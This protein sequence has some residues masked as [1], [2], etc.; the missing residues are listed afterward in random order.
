MRNVVSWGAVAITAGLLASAALACE[1]SLS[2]AVTHST[3]AAIQR[4][5]NLP[6]V[7]NLSTLAK[8]SKTKITLSYGG[9][10]QNPSLSLGNPA[11]SYVTEAHPNPSLGLLK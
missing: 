7:P 11:A 4:P 9:G 10:G 8:R 3:T 1:P 5:A 2:G 6:P